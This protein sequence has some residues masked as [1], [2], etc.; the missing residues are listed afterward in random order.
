MEYSY[1]EVSY[2]QETLIWGVAKTLFLRL[3]NSHDIELS[4]I[5]LT[6]REEWKTGLI[7]GSI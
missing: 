1:K 6:R 7:N 2:C 3:I 5:V 4:Y